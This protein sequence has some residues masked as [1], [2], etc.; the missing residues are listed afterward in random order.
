MGVFITASKDGSFI[1]VRDIDFGKDGATGLMAR[2]GTVHN[3]VTIEVR[4]NGTDGKLIGTINVPRTGGSDRWKLVTIDIEKVTGVH[5]V[6]F[7]LRGRGIGELLF[8][9]YWMFRE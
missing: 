3:D 1:K 5:D 2:V 4:L 9:D 8:F 6:Y 7:V